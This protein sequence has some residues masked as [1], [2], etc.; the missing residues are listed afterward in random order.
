MSDNVTTIEEIKVLIESFVDEREWKQFHN[1]KNLS[2][3]LS[4]EAAE[5]MELFQW[6]TLDEAKEVMRSDEI[7]EKAIDEIAD[8]MIYALAFCNRN[9]IDVSDAINQKLEKNIQK[10]PSEKFKGHF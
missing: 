7:R 6:L 8:V 4:I 10:Y 9:N 5:L 1:P 3:S 2:M